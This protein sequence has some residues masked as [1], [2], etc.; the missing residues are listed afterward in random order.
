MCEPSK[1]GCLNRVMFYQL[2]ETGFFRSAKSAIALIIAN[3][4]S[5]NRALSVGSS[6][7]HGMAGGN[8]GY[9]QMMVPGHKV[10]LIIGKGG[11]TIKNLQETTGARVVI[12]Q[13]I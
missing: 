6:M 11:E 3:E 5:N 10:G 7:N 8:T 13:V 2:H 1:N 12:V 4:G 9:F